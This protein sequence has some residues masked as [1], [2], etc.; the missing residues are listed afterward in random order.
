MFKAW[1]LCS[2]NGTGCDQAQ[3]FPKTRVARLQ[4]MSD[5]LTLPASCSDNSRQ[6][7]NLNPGCLRAWSVLSLSAINF[8]PVLIYQLNHPN[9]PSLYHSPAVDWVHPSMRGAASAALGVKP[10]FQFEKK[11]SGKVI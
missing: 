11:V 9:G 10:I 8:R 7:M 5:R 2:S 4:N 3:I 6:T 1:D